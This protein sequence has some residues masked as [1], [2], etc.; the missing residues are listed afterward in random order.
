MGEPSGAESSPHTQEGSW[1]AIPE[2]GHYSG[3]NKDLSQ[4]ILSRITCDDG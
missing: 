3:N 2:L 4:R 1:A